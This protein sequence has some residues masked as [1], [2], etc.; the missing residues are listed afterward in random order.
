[1][2]LAGAR[3]SATRPQAELEHGRRTIELRRDGGQSSGD[4]WF[5]WEGR[6][7]SSQSVTC[8]PCPTTRREE[9]ARTRLV[10]GGKEHGEHQTERRQQQARVLQSVPSESQ[11]GGRRPKTHLGKTIRRLDFG[12]GRSPAVAAAAAARTSASVA[13]AGAVAS[14]SP[15]S[16]DSLLTSIRRVR[17]E[18]SESWGESTLEASQATHHADAGQL[19][20]AAHAPL[21][22]F[23]SPS[24]SAMSD[25]SGWGR[26]PAFSASTWRAR[27]GGAGG[28]AG[29]RTP[30]DSLPRGLNCSRSF[31]GGACVVL[32]AW[33]RGCLARRGPKSSLASSMPAP[34]LL[35]SELSDRKRG[36][37][38]DG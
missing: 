33:K 21:T 4:D 30:T 25:V 19:L 24:P 10:Q 29:R 8:R 11:Q 31:A 6:D 2:R 28:H 16:G 36:R 32:R 1:M 18:E 14:T 13:G 37:Q 27:R 17:E 23:D 20:R 9:R 7:Q 22:S 38:S 12:T 5:G 34:G 35:P 15:L 26:R 3:P